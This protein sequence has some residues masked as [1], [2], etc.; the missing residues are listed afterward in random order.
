MIFVLQLRIIVKLS[1][2]NKKA[3]S[4]GTEDTTLYL[5]TTFR[6]VP[7]PEVGRI[8]RVFVVYMRSLPSGGTLRPC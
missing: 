5:G 1:L 4:V 2:R 6:D 3:F 8:Q 7:I